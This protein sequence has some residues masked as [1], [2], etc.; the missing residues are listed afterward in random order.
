[1]KIFC[2]FLRKQAKEIISFKI[3]NMKLLLKEQQESM[4]HMKMQKSVIFVNKHLKMSIWKME[5]IVKLKI[6]DIILEI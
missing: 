3:R 4:N 5:N 1:M 6:I 2:E